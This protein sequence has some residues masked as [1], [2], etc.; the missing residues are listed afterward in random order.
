ME[1]GIRVESS[2]GYI[3]VAQADRDDVQINSEIKALTQE[4]LDL[5]EVVV[6]RLENGELFV[7]AV[8]PE[9]R[10]NGEGCNFEIEIPEANDVSLTTSNGRINLT[11]LN[12]KAIL[13]TSNGSVSVRDFEGAVQVKTSNGKVSALTLI[14]R[15]RIRTL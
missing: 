1:S 10:K 14:T 3:T 4:R 7:E 15:S 8:F 9:K 6:E 11:G 13:Q 5:C 12:G 2:N